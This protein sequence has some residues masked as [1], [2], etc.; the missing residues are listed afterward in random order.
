MACDVHVD[1]VGGGISLVVLL[2]DVDMVYY[3]IKE[4]FTM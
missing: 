3:R 2:V 1:L 4:L